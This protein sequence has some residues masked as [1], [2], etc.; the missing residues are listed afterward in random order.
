MEIRK[1]KWDRVALVQFSKAIEYIA[2]DSIQ[3]AEKVRI[4]ILQKIEEN[5]H[6]PRKVPS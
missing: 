1:I 3:H 2:E 6:P 4:E 5:S